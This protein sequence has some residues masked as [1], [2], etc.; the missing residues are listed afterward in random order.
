VSVL[1]HE[2]RVSPK[3]EV[4]FKCREALEEASSKLKSDWGR[5]LGGV[6]SVGLSD[7]AYIS[8]L[9]CEHGDGDA[10]L[11]SRTKHELQ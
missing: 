7:H 11:Q 8:D 9:F 2:L 1:V 3:S 5:V 10:A 4:Q 6:Y